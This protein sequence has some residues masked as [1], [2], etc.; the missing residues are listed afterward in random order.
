MVDI[1]NATK[2]GHLLLSLETGEKKTEREG[3]ENKRKAR[4]KIY[5]LMGRL[6][7]NIARNARKL[8]DMASSQLL[9]STKISMH[10]YS[11]QRD[12]AKLGCDTED[13]D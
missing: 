13:D 4:E 7:Y 11:A 2:L 9:R 8:V 5:N 6:C 12:L 1:E 3:K 10:P